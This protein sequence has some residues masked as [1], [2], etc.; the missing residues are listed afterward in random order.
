MHTWR[1]PVLAHINRNKMI[2][3]VL[4]AA[5]AAAVVVVEVAN[6]DDDLKPSGSVLLF[7][8]QHPNDYVSQATISMQRRGMGTQ[9]SMC[10]YHQTLHLLQHVA[11]I[12]YLSTSFK[13]TQLH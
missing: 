2:Y 4:V 9:S 6:S 10:V 5:V 8:M 13:G 7:I 11:H 3:M 12:S 1:R